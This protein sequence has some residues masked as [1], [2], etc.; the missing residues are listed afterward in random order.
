MCSPNTYACKGVF[1]SKYSN[2][3]VKFRRGPGLHFN[4]FHYYC[5]NFFFNELRGERSLES[6]L[7]LAACEKNTNVKSNVKDGRSEEL[8]KGFIKGDCDCS[9]ALKCSDIAIV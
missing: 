7:S 6:F 3:C 4:A 9:G 2:I 1:Q 8:T 5:N